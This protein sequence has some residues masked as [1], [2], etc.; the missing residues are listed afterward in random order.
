M[1]EGRW[2]S[3]EKVFFGR[4]DIGMAI[5]DNVKRQILL[6]FLIT[7]SFFFASSHWL[8]MF[9][10]ILKGS[11]ETPANETKDFI[12]ENITLSSVWIRGHYRFFYALCSVCF[13]SFTSLPTFSICSL[14]F[15]ACIFEKGSVSDAPYHRND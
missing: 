15:L 10:L 6:F 11:F 4:R 12:A 2:F 7:P 14:N 8:V 3:L 13:D 9:Y 1:N 5:D